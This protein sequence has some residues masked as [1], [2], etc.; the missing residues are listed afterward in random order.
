[1]R[2][3]NEHIAMGELM[4]RANFQRST[5]AA[6]VKRAEEERQKDHIRTSVRSHKRRTAVFDVDA[7]AEASRKVMKADS[8]ESLEQLAESVVLNPRDKPAA[9]MLLANLKMSCAKD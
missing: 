7:F 8:T 3:Y 6:L 4:G 5:L 9:I 1:M 2:P